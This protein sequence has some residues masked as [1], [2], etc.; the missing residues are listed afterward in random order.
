[1][2]AT[3]GYLN[4]SPAGGRGGIAA[5]EGNPCWGLLSNT[6]GLVWAG[7][8]VGCGDGGRLITWPRMSILPLLMRALEMLAP[9]RLSSASILAVWRSAVRDPS[10]SLSALEV[11]ASSK[12]EPISLYFS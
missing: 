7:G 12:L 6:G 4:V 11:A 2:I 5:T 1:M 8:G 9:S 10:N 3:G